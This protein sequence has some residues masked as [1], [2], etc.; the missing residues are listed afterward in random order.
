MSRPPP[1]AASVL[2]TPPRFTRRSPAAP[3][4]WCSRAQP[5]FRRP[6]VRDVVVASLSVAAARVLKPAGASRE[7][8][9][10]WD[11]DEMRRAERALGAPK[12]TLC[13]TR[14]R[15][16]HS[17]ARLERPRRA[18]GEA[19]PTLPPLTRR[20]CPR[21]TGQR[22][23]GAARIVRGGRRR[24]SSGRTRSASSP[25]GAWSTA[26]VKGPHNRIAAGWAAEWSARRAVQVWYER[27]ERG[28]WENVPGPVDERSLGVTASGTGAGGAARMS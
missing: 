14:S 25:V 16:A 6:S 21:A 19:P 12:K 26:N 3:S 28:R 24:A 9:R 23:H 1:C 17:R 13:P 2:A 8:N 22:G 7:S 10:G 11:E 18:G 20:A 15:S 5:A 27:Q 4:G